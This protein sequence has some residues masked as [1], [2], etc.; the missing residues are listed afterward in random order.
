MNHIPEEA[1]R[2]S[3]RGSR[4]SS[5]VAELSQNTEAPEASPYVIS[6]AKYKERL[7]E[8]K[9]LDGNKGRKA[10]ETLKIVGTKIK[11]QTDYQTHSVKPIPIRRDGVY[12][13]LFNGLEDDIEIKEI[14]LQQ[15]AR[16]FYFDIP[17]EKV[18]YVVAITNKHLETKKVRR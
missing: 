1:A 5:S 11:R 10:V 15:N 14:K 6:F 7:C 12:K 17:S 8:I 4:I 18:F 9:H 13:K 16:I 3:N 2:Q